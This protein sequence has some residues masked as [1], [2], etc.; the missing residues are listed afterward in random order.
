[1]TQ[2]RAIPVIDYLRRG[3]ALR[4]PSGEA[5]SRPLALRNFPPSVSRHRKAH[6]FQE[7]PQRVAGYRRAGHPGPANGD[8]VLALDREQGA[9]LAV[10]FGLCLCAQLARRVPVPRLLAGVTAMG[11]AHW[12][13]GIAAVADCHGTDRHAGRDGRL[14]RPLPARLHHGVLHRR[15]DRVKEISDWLAVPVGAGSPPRGADLLLGPRV[16]AQACSA[17]RRAGWPRL[18]RLA[19]VLAP[20]IAAL[21]VPVI[22]AVRGAVVGCGFELALSA[23]LIVASQTT[24]FISPETGTGMVPL[25]GAV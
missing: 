15:S 23:D 2:Q 20:A 4:G 22:A 12:T 24:T 17:G 11:V 18:V 13:A 25:A 10:P 3:E 8:L 9:L 16:P 7:R 6:A 19:P 5:L 14:R 21:P 1:M